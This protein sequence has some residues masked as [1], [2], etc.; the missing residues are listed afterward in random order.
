MYVPASSAPLTSSHSALVGHASV[1]TLWFAIFLQLFLML[2]VLH[3]LATDSIAMHRIQISVFGAV[4]IVFAVQG[5]NQTI[6][7]SEPA[8]DAVAAGWLILAI[9]D[10]LWTLYFTSEED[11]LMFYI[12]NSMGTGGL[13]PPGRRR[14]RTQSVH[15]MSGNGYTAGYAAAGSLGPVGY[16]AKTNSMAGPIGSGASFKNGSV[17]ARS[18][19]AH[20]MHQVALVGGDNTQSAGSPMMGPGAA[21]L[22]AGGGPVPPPQSQGSPTSAVGS[23]P[24]AVDTGSGS[25]PASSPSEPP[26]FTVKARAQYACTSARD[27]ILLPYG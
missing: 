24:L 6:F 25:P 14:R 20:S 13:T 21:G 15:N 23:V 3:T 12:F 26:Q 8:L 4:A 17:D 22:G 2:G 7:L 19:N 10:I 5:V 18:M 1:G 16:D 11:S 9:V 27:G